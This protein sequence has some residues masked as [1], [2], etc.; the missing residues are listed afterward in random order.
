L[1]AIDSNILVYAQQDNDQLNRHTTA[2]E[3][4]AKSALKGAVIP[5]QVLG[6]FLNVCRTKLKMTPQDSVGQVTD[7]LAVFRCPVT[8]ADD[9]ITA[10]I[11][12][13]QFQLQFFDALIV[14]VARRVEASVLLS[15]DMQDGLD[16]DGV[17]IVN[18]FAAANETLL[19]D[20]FATAV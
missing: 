6:E 20:Y 19:A 15:E 14:S 16:I 9:L 5:V 2:I 1:I 18:P 4:V 11:T 13:D 17:K 10:A 8:T 7:Y 12:A 3:I